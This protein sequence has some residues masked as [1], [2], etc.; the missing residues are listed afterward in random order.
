M[1]ENVVYFE[2]LRR[3]YD[4]AVGKIGTR[5]IDFIATKDEQKIYYQVTED[6]TA[7]S[8]GERELAPLKM[9]RDN[10]RKVVVAMRTSSTACVDGIEIVNLVDFLLE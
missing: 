10:Y 8:T 1:I 7:D 4:V 6:M 9:I 2:L 5:E 3:G